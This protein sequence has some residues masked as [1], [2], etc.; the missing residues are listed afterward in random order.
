MRFALIFCFALT[1]LASEKARTPP[2]VDFNA[3]SPKEQ[4]ELVFRLPV[5]PPGFSVSAYY[6]ADA[7]LRAALEACSLGRK[8][9]PITRR[10]AEAQN[11]SILIEFTPAKVKAVW[12][13]MV[14]FVASRPME[15]IPIPFMFADKGAKRY[16][17]WPVSGLILDEMESD[18]HVPCRVETELYGK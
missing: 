10:E 17:V 11:C 9:V 8:P 5:P 1:S 14:I 12:G 18:D 15:K 16:L 6:V 3:L 2:P 4:E 7:G 13:R